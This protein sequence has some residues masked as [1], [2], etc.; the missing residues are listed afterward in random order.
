MRLFQIPNTHLM[1]SR[2]IAVQCVSC[3]QHTHM[4][5]KHI[6][7]YFPDPQHIMLTLNFQRIRRYL[8]DSLHVYLG[9][10]Y[11]TVL[12]ATHPQQTQTH[13]KGTDI[14]KWSN[15]TLPDPQHTSPGL[16]I[17]RG[18]VFLMSPPYMPDNDVIFTSPPTYSVNSWFLTCDITFNWSPARA[19]GIPICHGFVYHPPI[20]YTLGKG[21]SIIK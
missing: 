19:F 13:R 7:W 4:P 1:D 2:Y 14:I 17:Y 12:F 11:V 21:T 15:A 10:R 8:A 9:S 16:S 20:A 5:N 18:S 6:M 3:P